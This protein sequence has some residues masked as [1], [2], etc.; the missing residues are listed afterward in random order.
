MQMLLLTACRRME[1]ATL[2]WSD[3]DLA[4]KTIVIPAARYKTGKAHL[5]PLSRQAVALLE[6]LP[7]LGEYVFTG[8]GEQAMRGFHTRKEKIDAL[9]D[10]PIDYDL[11]DLRR[12]V[13]P[14][15]PACAFPRAPPSVAS[16]IR[17]AGSSGTTTC[18]V[19]ATRSAG[20]AGLGRPRR[21][22]RHRPADEGGPASSRVAGVAAEYPRR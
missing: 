6:S 15:S 3:V 4:E 7:R 14:D 19:T 11:H 13:A 2:L 18:T 10:P 16:G 5:V 8:R 12:T 22:G 1:L 9:I 21:G 17:R 20:V